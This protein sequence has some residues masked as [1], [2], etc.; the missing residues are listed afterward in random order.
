MSLKSITL[1]T[2]LM[3]CTLVTQGLIYQASIGSLDLILHVCAS[4]FCLCPFPFSLS[5]AHC[6]WPSAQQNYGAHIDP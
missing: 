6:T 2:M 3:H 5:I 1:Y 4:H